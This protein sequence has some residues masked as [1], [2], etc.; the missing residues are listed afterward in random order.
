MNI[1][2]ISAGSNIG[3][4]EAN[5]D[6]GARR[7]G[8]RGNL[9]RI[10]SV[11]ETEPVGYTDQSWFLNQVFE[12]ETSLTPHELLARCNEIERDGGRVRTFPNAP[13]T[14]DLDILLYG[15]QV[16]SEP[17]LTV[18][19]PRMTERRFVLEPLAEIAPELLHPVEKKTIRDLLARCPDTAAA[20][21]F[22]VPPAGVP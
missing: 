13:R 16:I 20:R 10:S 18:P 4:R 1:A 9:T 3:D 17:D 5:L 22:H 11:F 21:K 6:F 12:L 2:Y 7:L 8:K 14:L 19:H 15:D